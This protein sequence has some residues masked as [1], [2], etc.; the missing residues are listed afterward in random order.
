MHILLDRAIEKC[1]ESRGGGF[2][3]VSEDSRPEDVR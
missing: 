2:K 1:R 3:H